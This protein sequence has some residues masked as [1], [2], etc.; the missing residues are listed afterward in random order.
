MRIL[1][2]AHGLFFTKLL[3]A[4]LLANVVALL[5]ANLFLLPTVQL[6]L[7]YPLCLL[8]ALA[9]LRATN[10]K[11][12]RK[13]ATW[14]MFFY[15]TGFALLVAALRLPYCADWL[16]P[17]AV[18]VYWDDYARVPELV[19]MTQSE[20]FPLRFF[21]NQEFLFSFYYCALMPMAWLKIAIPV[22]TL[23]N[24]VFLG[25]AAYLFL[26]VYSILELSSYF[27]K[28][29]A[30]VWLMLLLSTGFGGLDWLLDA[31]LLSTPLVAPHGAWPRALFQA[32]AQISSFFTALLWTTHH[33]IGFYSCVLAA[34]LLRW[35]RAPRRWIKI[36]LAG[37]L[38]IGAFYSSIFAAFPALLVL[39]FN[40]RICARV[41]REH[42]YVIALLALLFCVPLYLLVGKHPAQAF[43]FAAFQ[44][45]VSNSFLANKLAGFP[46][47]LGLV[48]L[49]NLGGTPLLCL[50]LHKRFSPWDR[51]LHLASLLFFLSTYVVAFSGF[52][53]YSMRGMLLPAFL[54]FY[55]VAKYGADLS[56]RGIARW[57]GALVL[58]LG[59]FATVLDYAYN[60]RI[61]SR[62]AFPVNGGYDRFQ[63]EAFVNK[64]LDELKAWEIEL[65][66]A[67]RQSWLF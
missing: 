66:R 56:K 41:I 25:V 39:L 1:P 19:S 2:P 7:V 48:S 49:V 26:M 3:T 27:F 11:R 35:S 60:A 33:A 58:G 9:V 30:S 53:N 36:L 61:A 51:A 28:N 22:L 64:P 18:G 29:R 50:W 5:A 20:H 59:L 47:W 42:P 15:A 23:K 12:G 16:D 32:N 45:P 65:L 55:L 54:Y 46:L 10:W 14:P 37:L 38:L 52:N 44:L 43:T 62:L 21:A 34:A 57:A 17:H 8:A 63:G 13:L 4:V 24:C 40:L 31:G 67:P 6:A